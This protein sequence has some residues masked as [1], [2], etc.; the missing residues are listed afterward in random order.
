[1]TTSPDTPAMT[2]TSIVDLLPLI[3]RATDHD[4][5]AID[6]AVKRRRTSLV[7]ATALT[8]RPGSRVRLEQV[9]PKYL[10]GLE[11]TVITCSGM[12]VTV[13]LDRRID[14]G[15]WYGLDVLP[16]IPAEYVRPL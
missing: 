14:R 8:L 13:Q 12:R 1:M 3:A 16:N 2:A 7:A 10:S 15:A 6:E 5:A 9:R 11:G 4:L